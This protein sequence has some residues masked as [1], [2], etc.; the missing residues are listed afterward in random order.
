MPLNIDFLQILLHLLNFV[1]LAG[2]LTFL[3]YKPVVKFLESRRAYFAEIEEKNKEAAKE[4]E[5]LRIEYEKKLADA[6]ADIANKKKENE[7]QIAEMTAQ[8]LKEAHQKADAIVR[9]AEQEAEKRKEHILDSAQTEIGELVLAAT[10]KLLSDTVTP[11]RNIALYDEF[12]RLADEKIAEER[13]K[14]G[15][16]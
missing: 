6:D 15:K 11:E 7:K 1:I 13:V 3:L 5:K 14:N 10:Q 4:A 9:T 12:I 16:K 2:G 8:T